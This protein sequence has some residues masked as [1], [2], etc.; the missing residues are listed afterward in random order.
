MLGWLPAP[1]RWVL[2]SR[3]GSA[4][5]SQVFVAS[6][7]LLAV[8]LG[9]G[10]IT[11]RALGPHGRGELA[12]ITLW[13]Q[14]V[15]YMATLGIPGAVVYYI[16]SLPSKGREILTAATGLSVVLGLIAA[17]AGVTVA[18]P[19]TLA[20]YGQTT[21]HAAQLFML[22]AP[23]GLIALIVVGALQAR[24]EF[25][26]A[27]LVGLAPPFLTL[28]L[29]LAMLPAHLVTPIRAA[30]A[31]L[32][33]SLL[34]TVVAARYVFRGYTLSTRG[35]TA[36]FK[37][38]VGYGVRAYPM[39]L[40][41]TFGASIDQAIVVGMVGPVALGW[42]VVALRG[43]RVAS[44][45]QQAV[46][47]VLFARAAGRSKEEV[48]AITGRSTRVTMLFTTA[49]AL[50]LAVAAVQILSLIYGRAFL[51][52]TRVFQLLL[53]EALLSGVARIIGQAFFALGRPGTVAGLQAVGLL[54]LVVLLIVL[55]PR[56]GILGAGLALLIS[57]VARL[58]FLLG[59]YPLVLHARPPSFLLRRSDMAWVREALNFRGPA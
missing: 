29:L 41:G 5:G 35:V 14:T 43:S 45:I 34:V 59:A 11:A 33:P 15:A 18:A 27:N 55:V 53:L 49:G 50:I 32:I 38:L 40:I 23:A 44:M 2:A 31:T 22:F 56:F 46:A 28:A 25:R 37:P 3:S 20:H 24:L 47:P 52:A 8:N 19:L 39:D 12:A 42:Y 13:P 30:L 51:P 7:L 1:V 10:I 16:R 4:Q 9:T 54:I 58:I 36:W 21:L 48:V 6:V 17:V 26:I 57:T